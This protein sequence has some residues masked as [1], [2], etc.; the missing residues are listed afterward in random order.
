[1]RPRRGRQSRRLSVYRSLTPRS[2]IIPARMTGTVSF[3]CGSDGH[4]AVA[5]LHAKQAEM[6]QYHTLF[7]FFEKYRVVGIKYEFKRFSN[8]GFD[9]S[10]TG[11]IA[12]MALGTTGYTIDAPG[13]AASNHP[14]PTPN[15]IT[16][17][18]SANDPGVTLD[19]AAGTAGTAIP[20]TI[21]AGTPALPTLYWCKPQAPGIVPTSTRMMIEKWPKVSKFEF[22]ARRVL[23]LTVPPVVYQRTEY[24]YNLIN[25]TN[26]NFG[27]HHAGIRTR[28]SPWWTTNG[29]TVSGPVEENTYDINHGLTYMGCRG[30]PGKYTFEVTKTVLIEYK[31]HVITQPAGLIVDLAAP[32]GPQNP[33]GRQPGAVEP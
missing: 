1:M 25:S 15:A 31:G 26:S 20:T 24:A 28:R 19:M 23:K 27:Y 11:T 18:L 7:N 3:T 21:Q 16:G 22:G 32:T 13:L 4:S 17:A 33:R 9:I 29:T 6:D 2:T 8:V 14:V 30:A 5:Q 12:P 10:G